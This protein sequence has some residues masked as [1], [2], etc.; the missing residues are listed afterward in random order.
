MDTPN[1]E[2]WKYQKDLL[3]KASPHAP[4][5]FPKRFFRCGLFY[6]V[7]DVPTGQEA[8]DSQGASRKYLNRH[9]RNAIVVRVVRVETIE[10][11]VTFILKVSDA[12]N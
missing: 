9:I 12:E 3:G 4:S 10:G 2:D 1:N 5:V 6:D 7:D 11:Q 8:F